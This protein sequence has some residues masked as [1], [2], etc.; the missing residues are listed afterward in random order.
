MSHIPYI[1]HLPFLSVRTSGLQSHLLAVCIR[2][3]SC[4][5]ILFS[6]LDISASDLTPSGFASPPVC[7]HENRFLRQANPRTPYPRHFLAVTTN[8]DRIKYIFNKITSQVPFTIRPPTQPA[9]LT[10][11]S[12]D[13]Q[14]G[15]AP[16][17]LPW[18]I[19]VTPVGPAP[20]MA[21][22]KR[23]HN[24]DGTLVVIDMS[25][26]ERARGRQCKWGS[27]KATTRSV[28]TSY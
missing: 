11:V 9:S 21:R 1:R 25:H 17:G 7:Q 15:A 18:P 26:Q 28:A 19:P 6:T 24:S 5:G 27:Q 16:M 8:R 13:L 14:R 20:I 4:L 10:L 12:A 23:R 3:S 22:G 2:W